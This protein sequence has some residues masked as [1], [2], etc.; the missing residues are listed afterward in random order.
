MRRALKLLQK[1]KFK[2]VTM[3]AALRK[4]VAITLQN[5]L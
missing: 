5:I 4:A 2:G 3:T 1:S